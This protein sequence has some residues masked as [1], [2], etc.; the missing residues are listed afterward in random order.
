MG[1]YK[2]Y[3]WDDHKNEIIILD[4]NRKSLD[5]VAYALVHHDSI[6]ITNPHYPNQYRMIVRIDGTYIT[7]ALEDIEDEF[8]E[9][10]KLITAWKASS[11]EI[12]K[13]S[14]VYG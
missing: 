8:G 11:S 6:I 13:W 4:Q 3:H 14:E 12:E 7:A 1:H 2:I 5:E 9:F 10:T